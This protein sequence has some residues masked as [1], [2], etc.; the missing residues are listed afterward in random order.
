M[1]INEMKNSRYYLDNNNKTF[2]Q[3][4][5][6]CSTCINE[7]YCTNCK[8][9]HHF[10]YNEKGKC[11][12]KPKKE[13]LLYLDEQT[14]TYIKCPEGTEKVENNKCIENSNIAIIIILTI[15]ILII[16]IGLLFFIKRIVSRK[17][18]ENEIPASLEENASNN[19]LI[20]IFL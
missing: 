10:I 14:N 3:C 18:L 7:A 16:I 20:N 8:E 6:E 13:D 9:G 15:V 19:Q 4:L 2:K 5:N 11:I 17:K 1:T 12:S